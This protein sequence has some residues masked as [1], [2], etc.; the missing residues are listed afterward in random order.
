MRCRANEQEEMADFVL[1]QRRAGAIANC[2][3][4]ERLA[5]GRESNQIRAD[6]NVD[7]GQRTKAIDELE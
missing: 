3:A 2:G 5:M 6:M 1:R 4:G 7:V